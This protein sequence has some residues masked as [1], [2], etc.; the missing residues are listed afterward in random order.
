MLRFVIH[1]LFK[2]TVCLLIGNVLLV[3]FHRRYA[4]QCRSM[5]TP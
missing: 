4:M 1:K 3:E 2:M 5:I